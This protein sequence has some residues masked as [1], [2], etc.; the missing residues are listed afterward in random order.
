MTAGC[1]KLLQKIP[2][3]GTKMLTALQ[4]AIIQRRYPQNLHRLVYRIR[5]SNAWIFEVNMQKIAKKAGKVE[6]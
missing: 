6:N 2:Y 5:G 3:N 1:G 4:S